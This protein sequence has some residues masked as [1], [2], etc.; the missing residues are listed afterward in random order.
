MKYKRFECRAVVDENSLVVMGGGK[1]SSSKGQAYCSQIVE[2]FDF[3]TSKWRYLPP[4]NEERRA[5]TAEIV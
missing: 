3:K 1:W 4:M 5:F 2:V